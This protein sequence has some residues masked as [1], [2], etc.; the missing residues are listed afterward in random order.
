MEKTSPV[1]KDSRLNRN[2]QNWKN[3]LKL[4]LK[5]CLKSK[6]SKLR[7]VNG[8]Q[9]LTI[10][11][12]DGSGTRRTSKRRKKKRKR[13]NRIACSKIITNSSN[14]P[15]GKGHQASSTAMVISG[16]AIKGN[17]NGSFMIVRQ[18]PNY[19]WTCMCQN[20]WTHRVLM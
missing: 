10:P 5:L 4:T 1:P 15:R 7:K 16:N 3:C 20:S 8:T 14:R 12:I 2:Y 13:R 9:M 11:P 18:E 19:S 17:M 6:P